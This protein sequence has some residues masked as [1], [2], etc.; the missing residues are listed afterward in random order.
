MTVVPDVS[1]EA[2]ASSRPSAMPGTPDG[3]RRRRRGC[4]PWAARWSSAWPT[5]ASMPRRTTPS[6]PAR[7]RASPAGGRRARPSAPPAAARIGLT[8]PRAPG[9][10]A[11]RYPGRGCARWSQ[12]LAAQLFLGARHDPDHHDERHDPERHPGHGDQGEEGE[13]APAALRAEVAEPDEQ[14][15]Q[16][17]PSGPPPPPT[18]GEEDPDGGTSGRR[19][20]VLASSGIVAGRGS[21]RGSRRW[22]AK[23]MTRRSMP[24]P[25]PAVGRHARTRAPARSPRRAG[26]PPRRPRSRRRQLASKRARCSMG[27]FSSVKAFAI[28]MRAMK[29]S[30]RST[31]RGSVR[32]LRRRAARARRGSRR[33]KVGLDQLGS[34]NVSKTSVHIRWP[35][36]RPPRAASSPRAAAASA[37]P[38]RARVRSSKQRELASEGL[39]PAASR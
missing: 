36:S 35:G 1:A 11:R 33:T 39:R 9:S 5:S 34:T 2:S 23:S 26:A 24:M 27:S 6:R 25:S 38:A 37:A 13:R 17:C 14:L 29:S 20:R 22:S 7:G 10:P 15:E 19:L 3:A 31:S 32:L 8:T 28:S 18:P 4:P 21:P 16:R 12:D 30:K